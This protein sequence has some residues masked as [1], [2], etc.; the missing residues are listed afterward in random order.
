M[1]SL[2][3]RGD[4]YYIAFYDATR[5]PK[6]KQVSLRVTGYRAAQLKSARLTTQYEEGSYDPWS[7]LPEKD[8]TTLGDAVQQFL[9]TRQ[10]LSGQSIQK[11]KSVLGQLV[12]F[13][14]VDKGLDA[15]SRAAIQD[16]IDSG[17]RRPITKKTY[18]T[19]LSPFFNWL[20]QH[21]QLND[22]PIPHIRLSRISEQRPST[23]SVEQLA[24]LEQSI[25]RYQRK[26]EKISSSDV[27]WMID[28]VRLTVLLGLRLSE[29][30]QLKWED[31]NRQ[32]KRVQ[33]GGRAGFQTKNRRIRVLPI[34][35]E[36]ARVLGGIEHRGEFVLTLQNGRGL[37]PHYV[38]VRFKKFIRLAGLP[39]E[40]TFHSLRHTCCTNLILSGVPIELVRRYMGHSSISV[41]QRYVH[42]TIGDLERYISKV[43]PLIFRD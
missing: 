33:I 17:N 2:F 12:K 20:I 41:T 15:C 38:S 13:I 36:L 3:K 34:S 43:N 18:S 40:V 28:V 21:H 24:K 23:V 30:C 10:N 7:P 42:S 37:R 16:F 32:T 1:P 31:V 19:T 22:N 6:R 11:Y 14:G 4:R 35:S 29:A 8:H 26:T 27:T 9:K 5:R 39:E 25:T